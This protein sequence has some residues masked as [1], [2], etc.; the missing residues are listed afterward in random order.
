MTI[1][2]ASLSIKDGA[3]GITPANAAG[4]Q[5]KIGIST[6]GTVNQLVQVSDPNTLKDLFGAGPMVEAAALV[7]NEA[8]GPVILCKAPASTNG[9]AGAV[10]KTGAGTGTLTVGRGPI[11]AITV[12]ITFA[13]ELG[14]AKFV[15]SL[16]GGVTWS[17]EQLLPGSGI[18]P[19]PDTLTTLTFV[20]GAPVSFVL[21]DQ[22]V[23]NTDG[24]VVKTGTGSGTGT[25]ASSPVD[26]YD[27][28]V[29]LTADGVN[30][31]AATA[32][33]KYS[34]DGGKTFS[35][36]YAVP[37]GGKIAIPGT[38][39][40]V[41]FVNGGAGTSFV[42]GDI[43]AFS[44]TAASYTLGECQA[45]I[46]ACLAAT[47]SFAAI[48][49]V[50][51]SDTVG[52]SALMFAAVATK[53][54]AA[55]AA[56]RY[57]FAVIECP[58]DTDANIK[59]AFAALA[60]TRVGVGAGIADVTSV[61]SG[62]QAKRNAA[63]VAMARASKVKASED[64]GRV[65]T[66][67]VRGVTKLY[68]NEEKTPGLD[69]ARFITLRTFTGLT[70]FFLTNGRLFSPNGSDFEFVQHRRV[71]DIGSATVRAAMLR[72]INDSVRVDS[73][74]GR[75]V[76]SDAQSIE[77]AIESDMR[78]TLTQPQLASDVSVTIDRTVNILSTKNLK[79]TF[80][81]IPF[82]Y[83]KSLE[84]NIGFSNPALTLT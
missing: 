4:V 51:A 34:L 28:Q 22:H 73:V 58:D 54:A 50:G 30:I 39:L 16:D 38:G 62:R 56:F 26:A 60:D 10:T 1:P 80:R 49:V 41:T 2:N 75:I 3:L 33:F 43:H 63:W 55:E 20:N 13:G 21:N 65:A 24:T 48:H 44:V 74:T 35:A 45:A 25:Q 23:F 11:G 71:M 36:E 81:I 15:Y 59:A 6:K 69:A 37:A 67:P 72:Y 18:F 82:G 64:L 79:A 5:V 27:V 19:V 47:D 32:A 7:L 66:G 68:R 42:K 77:K 70:G 61:I 84:G 14:V 83:V 31:A 12:K 53:M 9:T 78:A 40:F 29:V 76:E 8:G 57:I 46:D 52:N 17:L